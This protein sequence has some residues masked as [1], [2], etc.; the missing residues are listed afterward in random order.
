MAVYAHELTHNLGLGD[1]YNNPYAAPFQ[2][3][4]T[5]YWSM[6]SAVRSVVRRN[7]NRYHIPSTSTPQHVR[8]KI[9][10]A[11]PSD[12]VIGTLDDRLRSWR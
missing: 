1:N 7:H 12:L 4:A 3:A 5:G 11:P 8:D 6:M 9:A 10:L 2:R